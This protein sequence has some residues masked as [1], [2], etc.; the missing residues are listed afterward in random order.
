MTQTIN[1]AVA[2]DLAAIRARDSQASPGPWRWSGNV[3]NADQFSL[4]T[5]APGRGRCTIMG[6]V[7]EPCSESDLS[8]ADRE[9]M[10]GEDLD[11]ERWAEHVESYLTDPYTGETRTKTRLAFAQDGFLIAAEDI[12]VYEVAPNA[13]RRSDPAVYRGDIVG[14]RNADAEFIAHAR[15]DVS[16]LLAEVDRLTAEVEALRTGTPS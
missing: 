8:R 10:L 15:A 1:P 3:D 5:W 14:F 9:D 7:D 4:S 11:D 2:I 13:T 6:T 16:I 12:A